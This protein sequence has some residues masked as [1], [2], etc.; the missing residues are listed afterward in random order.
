MRTLVVVVLGALVGVWIYRRAAAERAEHE[1]W[2]EATDP[3]VPR[4]LR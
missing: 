1:L 4:D 3:V 2:A